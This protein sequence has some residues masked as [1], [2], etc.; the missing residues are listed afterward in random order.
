MLYVELEKIVG[1]IFCGVKMMVGKLVQNKDVV[2][3]FYKFVII[4]MD[5]ELELICEQ[6]E[7]QQ[8]IVDELLGLFKKY[9]FKCWMVDVELGKWLQVKGVKLVVKLQEMVVIDELFSE[10]VVVF[11]YENYVMILDD[12]MLESWIEKL[13]KVLVF[14]FDMEIDSLDNIVV[15]LVGF[16]FVIES[17]VVVY[18]FVVYDYL[19]VLD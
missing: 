17:G 13:K 10:L 8:L 16:L 5:V 6:F 18:V 1:F 14:V 3:L 19:D 2:Y 4:K 15:N 9:E 11:F 12:V 7:V